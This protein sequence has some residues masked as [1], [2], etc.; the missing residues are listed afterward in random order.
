M[1]QP[2]RTDIF[3]GIWFILI[4]LLSKNLLLFNNRIP[5]I[6]KITNNNISNNSFEI[7]NEAPKNA[8]GTDPTK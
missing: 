1:T 4:L 5:A 8:K 7:D 3:F 6:V 2:I